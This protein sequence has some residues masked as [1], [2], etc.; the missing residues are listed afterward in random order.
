MATLEKEMNNHHTEMWESTIAYKDAVRA[1]EPG[2]HKRQNRY[3]VAHRPGIFPVVTKSQRCQLHPTQ[4]KK[5][6]VISCH[7][8]RTQ[9]QDSKQNYNCQHDRRPQERRPSS[10]KH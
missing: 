6:N 3:F 2:H 1:D 5:R 7:H 9:L 8:P 4:S 10:S